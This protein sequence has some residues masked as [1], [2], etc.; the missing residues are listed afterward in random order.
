VAVAVR[1]TL[2]G[3]RGALVV[4]PDARDVDRV[5]AALRDEIGPGH[6]VTLTADLGP[7]ERYRRWLAVRRGTVHAVVGTR[8]A[9]FA[10]VR[11][12]GLVLVW[13]D[14]DDLHAEPHAPYPHVREVLALRAGQTGAAS[15]VGGFAV[16]AEAARQVRSGAARLV[17]ADR[18]GVRAVAPR[19]RVA[20]DDT[21]L[22][23][24]P[25]ARGARLPSSA[26]ET[27]RDALARGP[28]LV[29]VPR[30][31]Y[32]PSVACQ[33]CRRPARCPACQGPLGLTSGHAVARC[34]WCAAV[35]GRWRCPHCDGT[36]LR[37]QV[38]GAGRTAE[39]LGRAFPG[40]PVRTS[41]RDGVLS[42]VPDE[43]AL[44]VSTPGA[45]PVAGRGY[46]AALLL[47][48]WLLLS[49]P[50]LRAGEEAL[51]RW[52][53]AAALVR[54]AAEAGEV[55]LLAPPA[56]PA[57]QALVRW[58]PVGHAERELSERA[59]V[60]LP[61]AARFA[62]LVGPAEAVRELLSLVGLPSRAA[63]LGPVQLTQ[64][65]SAAADARPGER[66]LVRVPAADGDALAAALHAG[67]A[68]RSA[69]K[70]A[71]HVRVQVDPLEL[72]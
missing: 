3:G 14:G 41:G 28:V 17:A 4:V 51:R 70:A 7:A 68:V 45:E 23:R 59:A 62:A 38:V 36:R 63:V 29:Q 21:E 9:M 42:R 72:G 65:R 60:G 54:P 20:G 61:P 49:R 67:Q 11:D 1:A 12:L 39:E 43:P 16:T 55:V 64:E 34:R 31:G 56:S 52:L 57:A 47:D 15:V 2:A 69:R 35:A 71:H 19:V 37:A 44:V 24:D 18:D 27:A 46:A 30:R 32:L 10:P 40:V 66:A 25:A 5:D 50:D 13:D 58:D 6:H 33:D 22:A 48:G 8:A 26:W 53:A